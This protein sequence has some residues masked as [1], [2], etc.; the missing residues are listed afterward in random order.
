[1][2]RQRIAI[3]GGGC[4]GLASAWLLQHDHDVTLY[5]RESWLGGHARTLPVQHEG[6][7]HPVETGFKFFFDPV[8]PHLLALLRVLGVQPR[9]KPV[10]I[11]VTRPSSRGAERETLVLPPRTVRQ[12]WQVATSPRKIQELRW[13]LALMRSARAVVQAGD[14]TRTLAEHCDQLGMPAVISQQFV[15]PFIA[16]NWGAPASIMPHFPAY[17]VLKVL[18]RSDVMK[19]TIFEIDG[20]IATYV[21]ALVREL[22]DVPCHV[23]RGAVAIERHDSQ[24]TLRDEQGNRQAFDHVVVAGSARDAGQVLG[25]HPLGVIARQFTH[26]DTTIAHHTDPAFMPARRE[27]WALVNVHLERDGDTWQTEWAGWESSAPVFRTWLPRDGRVPQGTVH[28][29]TF[30]HLVVTPHNY[31]LH[32]QIARLQGHDGVSL[33]GMYTQ[34]VDNH[35]S[36]L[37]SALDLGARLAPDSANLAR[38]R[39]ELQRASVA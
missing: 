5:E 25:D 24:W 3:V 33:V 15:F 30:H 28:L 29:Q 32:Q 16:A 38:W 26:F 12:T 1:M 22:D 8:Y 4:A 6:V 7:A 2:T 14:W 19:P 27:D 35:E 9:R 31:A 36:V 13:F 17:S 21:Q 37:R 18:S 20:G 11:S 39:R 34:D 23:G 10:T